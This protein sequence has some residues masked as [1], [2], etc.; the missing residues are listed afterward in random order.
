MNQKLSDK[1]LGDNQLSEPTTAQET[2]A[3]VHHS[4]RN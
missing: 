3:Y 4:A 1:L 2:E